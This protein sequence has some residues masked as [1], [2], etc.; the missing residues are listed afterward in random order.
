M[1]LDTKEEILERLKVHDD[2]EYKDMIFG[3]RLVTANYLDATTRGAM[4]APVKAGGRY[5]EILKRGWEEGRHNPLQIATQIQ[6]KSLII[7]RP[8]V[9][10][11]RCKGEH[12]QITAA[13]RKGY[14]EHLWQENSLADVYRSKMLDVLIGGRGTFEAGVR[15]GKIFGEY[16]DALDVTW[17]NAYKP[18]AQKRFYFRDKHIPLSIAVR[19]YPELAQHEN[20]KPGEKGGERIVTVVCYRSKTTKAH[21]FKGKILGE[22]KP[23]DYGTI[24]ARA[25]TLF[26][27]LSV[28]HPTGQ[29]ESQIG[30][31]RLHLR[32]MRKWREIAL[33]GAPVGVARGNWDDAD[34]DQIESGKEGVIL[35]TK[36]AGDDF[37]W[38]GGPE[39]SKT[40]AELL[41]LIQQQL[42]E[43]SGVND[44]M[45]SRTDT[46]VDFATQLNLMASQSGIVG[47]YAANVHDTGILDD[48]ELLMEIG[49][50][51]QAPVEI[52]VDGIDEL[53]DE[54][55]PI[56]PLLGTDGV[57]E[58][59]P[60]GSVYKSSMQKLQETAMVA[61]TLAMAANMPPG[62]DRKFVDLAITASEVEDKDAWM[63]AFD[64]AKEQMAMQ[65]QLQMGAV[66]ED[67]E[68]LSGAQNGNPAQAV[69]TP[70]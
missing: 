11:S 62:L 1:Q 57:P 53:F 67:F 24:P 6:V 10:W 39:G 69:A 65:A 12:P 3:L 8:E 54:L 42:N 47:Q 68:A 33:R 21:I 52:D 34:L 25:A 19:H 48:A 16:A 2:P 31:L 70:A 61:S 51:F 17:D 22:P 50:R 41:Q 4:R 66:P 7:Q 30:P 5:A 46:K 23:N 37:A 40:D 45:R 26:E 35:R 28:R 55:M 44:F 9:R 56:N 36:S 38:I 58:M 27:E 32:L 43:A 49:H 63:D 64:S 18:M 60:G 13:V 15:D 14:F 20:W 29:V 59:K